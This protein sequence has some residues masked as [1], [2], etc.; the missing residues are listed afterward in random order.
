MKKQNKQRQKQ[1]LLKAVF[2]N[3]LLSFRGAVY[4]IFYEFRFA[5]YIKL[6]S[7]FN[8]KPIVDLSIGGVK[9]KMKLDLDDGGLSH[10]IFI[11]KVREYPNVLYFIKFLKKN[12]KN[13]DTLIDVGANIGYYALFANAIFKQKIKKNIKTYA[14]EPVLENYNLLEENIALNDFPSAKLINAA[15]GEKNRKINVHVPSHRN[16]SQIEGVSKDSFISSSPKRSVDMYSL[17]SIFSKN[18]IPLRRVLFRWDVEGYEYNIIKGNYG[19]FKKLKNAY[20]IMEFHSF[21][22]LEKKTIELLT[23]LKDLNFKLEFV[24]SCY[25]PYFLRMPKIV[26]KAL[27]RTWL[28]EKNGTNLGLLPEFKTIDDLIQEFRNTESPLYTYPNL[29]F[30]LSKEN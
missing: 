6:V 26:K 14:Y 18:K 2:K 9:Y 29:H 1:F 22:L 17:S 15:V 8:S 27:I 11:C 12:A 3:G 7:L 19:T 20:I 24:V 25:P 30:Y 16:L 13:I 21:F 28:M 5:P 4:Y 23:I 10:D